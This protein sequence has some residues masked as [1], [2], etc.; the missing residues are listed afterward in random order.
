MKTAPARHSCLSFMLML[1][2]FIYLFIFMKPTVS[3]FFIFIFRRDHHPRRLRPESWQPQETIRVLRH[4]AARYDGGQETRN[5]IF[6]VF[7]S[8]V[9]P[10]LT[11]PPPPTTTAQ[12]C[13][14][15]YTA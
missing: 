4:R 12:S 7:I 2:E 15:T 6:T 11:A 10:R 3:L 8:V 9:V 5:N 13:E 1:T 14:Y